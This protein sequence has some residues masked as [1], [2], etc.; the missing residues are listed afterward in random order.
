MIKK[1]SI[2]GITDV[3]RSRTHNEDD[4]AICK[5][6]SNHKWGFKRGEVHS[7]SELG[8]LLIVADGMGGENAGEVASH[9]AQETVKEDFDALDELPDSVSEREGLLARSILKAHQAVVNHQHKNLDTAGM[10]TTLIIAWVVEDSVHVAWSGDSRC[11]IYN[12]YKPL[13][14]FTED[15]SLVWQMVEENHMTPEEARVHPESNIVTQSL[16]D[17]KN[18]PQPSVKTTKLYKGNQ[19]ILCSD[20]LNGM[21]SDEQIESVLEDGGP[22]DETCGKLIKAANEAGGGDNITCLMLEV[23]EGAEPSEADLAAQ[24]QIKSKTTTTQILRKKNSSKSL[25]IGVLIVVIAVLAAWIY[26]DGRSPE[27]NADPVIQ[28]RDTGQTEEPVD[29][30]E[31]NQDPP[32][33]DEPGDVDPPEEEQ[34]PVADPDPEPAEEPSETPDEQSPLPPGNAERPSEEEKDSVRQ[35][36]PPV[37]KDTTLTEPGKKIQEP[38]DTMSTQP[39]LPDSTNADSTADT[40]ST[41]SIE[42]QVNN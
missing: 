12:G 3:G 31:T 37:Q 6:L 42:K 24:S 29:S 16:G 36:I 21:L 4:F 5:D 38:K 7:L 20:G 19:L 13:Y 18:P 11:Y 30:A 39:A 23:H 14:P 1:I 25:M 41:G 9:L 33:E 34:P 32:I 26:F 17:E 28:D 8:A 35:Q 27:A 40:T 22:I 10:G 15:H 2:F